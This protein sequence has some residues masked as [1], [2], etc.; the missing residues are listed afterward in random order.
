MNE[1]L[2]T[3]DKIDIGDCVTLTV[4]AIEG[5]RVYLGIEGLDTG[6]QGASVH[7]ERSAEPELPW[8]ELN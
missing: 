5:N 3:G 8:W 2:S 4:I 1:T 7:M 6:S